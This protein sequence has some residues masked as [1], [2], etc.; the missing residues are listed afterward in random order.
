MD[1][2]NELGF[3]LLN[4]SAQLTLCDRTFTRQYFSN[5][6]ERTGSGEIGIVVLR[7]DKDLLIEISYG[8]SYTNW[9]N[10]GE[11]VD[12]SFVLEKSFY[13]SKYNCKVNKYSFNNH[14]YY[15]YIDQQV[16]GLT[17]PSFVISNFRIDECYFSK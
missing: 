17:Y 5:K 11:Q 2:L 15:A 6:S 10:I 16:Q 12:K 8:S 9:E 1:K 13:S 4:R 7:K 14:L 3:S